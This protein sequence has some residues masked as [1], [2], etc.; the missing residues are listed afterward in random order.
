MTLV[1]LVGCFFFSVF[2]QH[3]TPGAFAAGLTL[4][5]GLPESSL[6]LVKGALFGLAAALIACYKGMSVGGGPQGVGNAVNETVVYSFIALFVINVIA[7][8]VGTTRTLQM[9]AAPSTGIRVTAP[10][11]AR[12]GRRLE[13]RWDADRLLRQRSCARSRTAFVRYRKRDHAPGRP[14][15]SGHRRAG[16]HRRHGGDRRLSH[17]VRR[18]RSSPCR[19]TTSSAGIG[20]EAMTGFISAYVNVRII[21]PAVAGIG[22]AATIGAGATAQLGAMRIAEEIDALEVMAVR[23]VA[24]LVSTG[25]RRGRR[26]DPA[27]LRGGAVRVPGRPVRH[28]RRSMASPPAST[29]TTS[30]LSSTRSTCSGRSCS[31]DHGGGR[32]HAGAHLLRLHRI[33]RSRRSRRGGRPR[34]T[35]LADR[36]DAAT[37]WRS[38]CPST[39]SPAT[40]TCRDSAMSDPRTGG[41]HPA[42]WTLI[43]VVATVGIIV[44]TYDAVL[45]LASRLRSG[46]ADLGP[47]RPGDGSRR[48][49]QDARRAGRPGRPDHRWAGPG[50]PDAG[51]RPGSDQVHPGQRRAE[52]GPPRCSAPSTSTWSI[53]SDPSPQRLSAGAVIRSDNVSTEVNTVFQNLVKVLDRSTRPSSMAC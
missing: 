29:T 34:G 8:A 51:D 50:A 16:A 47:G 18:A 36:V 3:V 2:V 49:G 25:G 21:S 39:A 37:C 11:G 4:L 6:G 52:S 1:G 46:D 26:G 44:A 22:L 27:V 23:S 41:M 35:R 15:E 14:D 32:D 5:T 13:S 7:T 42:W 12:R 48:Q 9:T 43:F 17:I 31:G 38:R 24:Y 28:H 20:V 33:G 19:D 45:G 10:D 30:T 40:S 53:P